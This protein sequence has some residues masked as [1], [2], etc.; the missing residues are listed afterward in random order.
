MI[1]Y[2][3]TKTGCRKRVR[4]RHPVEWYPEDSSLR[5]CPECSGKLSRDPEVKRRHRRE[6]CDCLGLPYP[7]RRTT[8]GC[9]HSSDP[10]RSWREYYQ[11][12]RSTLSDWR[13]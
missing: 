11:Y 12:A 4:L 7:H 9:V 6:T 5:V 10:D 2:R 13:R 3:C 1:H 8:H